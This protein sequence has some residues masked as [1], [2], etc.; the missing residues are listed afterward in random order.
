LSAKFFIDGDDFGLPGMTAG[1]AELSVGYSSV[2]GG[3]TSNPI[4]PQ[5]RNWQTASL[6][7]GPGAARTASG[8]SLS[9]RIPTP[10]TGDIYIDDVRVE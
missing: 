6:D 1:V 7:L 4:T 2:E 5:L 10:W 9:V 3:I 8:I